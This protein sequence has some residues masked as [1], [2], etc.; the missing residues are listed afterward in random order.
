[1][2][3][4]TETGCRR[5]VWEG[6]DSNLFVLTSSPVHSHFECIT[7]PALIFSTV[8]H[9]HLATSLQ[10]LQMK[11]VLEGSEFSALVCVMISI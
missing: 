7:N 10:S 9:R 2:N 4:I 1:M 6:S 5:C 11:L 8:P 3:V